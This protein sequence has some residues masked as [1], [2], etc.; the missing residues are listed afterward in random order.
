MPLSNTHSP[1]FQYPAQTVVRKLPKSE[2]TLS[3]SAL[4]VF[5]FQELKHWLTDLDERNLEGKYYLEWFSWLD[6]DAKGSKN[7]RT[8]E[9][10]IQTEIPALRKLILEYLQRKEDIDTEELLDTQQNY[11][12]FRDQ[13]DRIK[14]LLLEDVEIRNNFRIY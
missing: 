11:R 1:E 13:F 14:R 4:K 3:A 5:L 6:D 7:V 8:F 12:E 9:R 2:E 10:L